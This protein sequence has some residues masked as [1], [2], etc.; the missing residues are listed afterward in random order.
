MKLNF[1]RTLS[2]LLAGVMIAT[3]V[4]VT[5]LTASAA[6]P[7]LVQVIFTTENNG[8]QYN[9][10][11]GLTPYAYLNS[12]SDG[13]D[14]TSPLQLWQFGGKANINPTAGTTTTVTPNSVQV[15]AYEGYSDGSTNGVKSYYNVTTSAGYLWT[16]SATAKTSDAAYNKTEDLAKGAKGSTLETLS[17]SK[18]K[19]TV[20][21]KVTAKEA[22]VNLWKTTGKGSTLAGT[23][24]GSFRVKIEKA[25][26]TFAIVGADG[27]A[28]AGENL[29]ITINDP[30]TLDFVAGPVV[31]KVYSSDTALSAANTFNVVSNQPHALEFSVNANVAETQ[32]VWA[33]SLSG[34]TLAQISSDGFAVRA[35]R[36]ADNVAQ[37]VNKN[38]TYKDKLKNFKYKVT[39]AEFIAAGQGDA[40]AYSAYEKAIADAHADPK[41]AADAA[42]K[43]TITITNTKS[44]KT[45]K[46][47]LTIV[48]EGFNGTDDNTNKV[49]YFAVAEGANSTNILLTPY[50]WSQAWPAGLGAQDY[51]ARSETTTITNK[52]TL[53]VAKGKQTVDTGLVLTGTKPA[54]ATNAKLLK[55]ET[56]TAAFTTK[57][58]ASITVKTNAKAGVKGN[59]YTVFVIFGKNTGEQF[60][61]PVLIGSLTDTDFTET[62]SDG[63]VIDSISNTSAARTVTV[64]ASAANTT[65]VTGTA[66]LTAL[67]PIK[68]AGSTVTIETSGSDSSEITTDVVTTSNIVKVTAAD[69]TTSVAYA[70]AIG[71]FETP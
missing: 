46:T 3:S 71:A 40:T 55:G 57:D 14:A 18:G 58:N 56:V 15:N 66:L 22:Y 48:N 68:A 34:V 53:L 10:T 32:Q 39:E 38:A 61:I 13:D 6:A 28:L 44:G 45:A 69:G 41:T 54:L 5:A 49:P 52:P 67:E 17:V 20:G 16:L 9:A 60:A 4:S 26:T 51:A 33:E 36:L 50:V 1:K 7:V 65:T 63:S 59:E 12:R 11:S 8:G 29:K 27:K 19:V 70:I 25:A 31:A 37:A 24:A 2:A 23:L 30:K 42:L 35:L 64:K 62:G 21:A 47:T 43:A